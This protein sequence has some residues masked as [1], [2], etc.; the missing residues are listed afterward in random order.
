MCFSLGVWTFPLFLW[1]LYIS[2]SRSCQ[3]QVPVLEMD[4]AQLPP[5]CLRQPTPAAVPSI[6]MCQRRA[7]EV[8]VSPWL[9]LSVIGIM[10]DTLVPPPL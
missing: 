10:F 3:H 8:P 6:P 5:Q 1:V 2:A 9:P 4:L 7:W